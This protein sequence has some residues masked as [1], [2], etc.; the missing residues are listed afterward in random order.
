MS[1]EQPAGDFPILPGLRADGPFPAWRDQLM[2]FGQFVGVWDLAVE[3]YDAAGKCTY[4]GH[5]EWSFAWILDGRAIQDVLVDLGT[6][7]SPRRVP[8]GTTVRYCHPGT[9]RWTV[10]YL[11]A[12]AGITVQLDGGQGDGTIV[13]E[14]AEL[15]GTLN[16][17]IFSDILPGSFTWSGYE[18]RSGSSWW[19][20]QRMLAIRRRQPT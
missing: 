3:Y 6:D 5:W 16:R 11:G 12:V 15:D 1:R 13:L 9:G 4:H 14:G 19:P 2:T 17:W 8:G 20:N 10:Y 7:A 18:S